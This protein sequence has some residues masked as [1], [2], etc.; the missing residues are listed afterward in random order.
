LGAAFILALATGACTGS[1]SAT[2]GSS[3]SA[4][5]EVVS[6]DTA[7]D[8]DVAP[9]VAQ[10]NALSDDGG[11]PTAPS[12][13]LAPSDPGTSDPTG[14]TTDPC[15]ECATEQAPPPKSVKILIDPI[16]YD[17][18]NRRFRDGDGKGPFNDR[19]PTGLPIAT[20]VI[21][22]ASLRPDM[23]TP[24]P[25][26]NRKFPDG[27]I[28]SPTLPPG[29]VVTGFVITAPPGYVWDPTSTVGGGGTLTVSPDGTTAT[30]TGLDVRTGE[31]LWMAIDGPGS[32][33]RGNLTL[34]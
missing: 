6:D 20:G 16:V 9:I 1:S 22:G 25:F 3:R 23:A 15:S 17:R 29:G 21:G 34:K 31:L 32:G 10:D 11:A 5:D 27:S 33:Y 18:P 7:L 13:P 28:L 2:L 19:Y 8:P 30:I 12:D 24:R 4:I 14:A 26:F